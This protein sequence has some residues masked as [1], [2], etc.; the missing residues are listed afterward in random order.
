MLVK[1]FTQE[2]GLLRC[3]LVISLMK[4]LL[5][6]QILAVLFSWQ[7][8]FQ[9]QTENIGNWPDGIKMTQ[10]SIFLFYYTSL[11]VI[12]GRS[13][14]KHFGTNF[15]KRHHFPFSHTL[16]YFEKW[17]NWMSCLFF[18]PSKLLLED[19]TIATVVFCKIR[20]VQCQVNKYKC[21]KVKN[22]LSYT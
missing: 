5:K 17:Y 20:K 13:F 15:Y 14:E 6:D 3:Y 22:V 12:R 11:L 10:K 4:F 1:S 18:P 7:M 16:R 21:S 19:G 9:V 8:F 2:L